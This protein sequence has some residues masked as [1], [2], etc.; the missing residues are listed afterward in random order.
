MELGY[1]IGLCVATWVTSPTAAIGCLLA[2]SVA[3]R[4]DGRCHSGFLDVTNALAA[5]TTDHMRITDSRAP[6]ESI[7]FFQILGVVFVIS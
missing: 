1:I 5:P 7:P 6:A 4:Y 3:S 2:S